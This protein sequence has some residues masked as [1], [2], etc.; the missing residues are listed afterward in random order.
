MKKKTSN[1]IQKHNHN[2]EQKGFSEGETPN[3]LCISVIAAVDMNQELLN[4]IEKYQKLI[5]NI[6]LNEY[7]VDKES[8]LQIKNF[9]NELIENAGSMK[10]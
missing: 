5:D 9:K 10:M 3:K 6:E 7:I 4:C 1:F 2:L 8:L